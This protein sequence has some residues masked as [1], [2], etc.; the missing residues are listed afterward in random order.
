MRFR[1]I[2]SDVITE[3]KNMEALLFITMVGSFVGLAA[4]RLPISIAL[5][6]S[7]IVGAVI[8]DTF[9]ISRLV[10]GAFG[11][12]DAILIIATAMIFMNSIKESGLLK[13]A[14]DV[15]TFSFRRYP[16]TLLIMMTLFI[17]SAG[18]ITGSSTAAV[19]TTGAIAFPVLTS[20]GLDRKTSGAL[21]AMSSIF[22]M[23]AP[24]VNIPVMI[25]GQGVDMPY[26]GFTYP[27]L[28]LTVPLAL[29]TALLL[30]GRNVK[31]VE[32][33]VRK[34][35][36][37]LI[38]Y[39]PFLLLIVLNI[40]DTLRITSFG[41]SLM[42]I[43][44]AL[45]ANLTAK[46]FNFFKTS[47]KAL[48]EALP[49]LSIL[50]GVGMFIEVMTM[51]GVRGFIVSSLISIPTP[52]LYITIGIGIPAFGAVSSFGAAS[53]LGVPFLLAFLGGNDIIVASALSLVAGLGDMVPPTALAGIFASH[54]V[55]EKNY[56][57]ILK[58]SFAI[59]ALVA[60]FGVTTVAFSRTLSVLFNSAWI[61]CILITALIVGVFL[62]D[63]FA[64]REL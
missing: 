1:T 38:L 7:S 45:S 8:S 63:I 50:A 22:G 5:L 40:L 43:I 29:L 51:S 32:I 64:R 39:I 31:L 61:L 27:L 34:K 16:R 41:L 30:A 57:V 54:V 52:L 33:K 11:Y 55:G 59:L 12:F 14:A 42:F 47:I 36:P 18:M 25:I 4:L 6:F 24:P 15:I 53:V 20:L 56:F 46:K 19:L 60:V 23:I 21:I 3:V 9:S 28:W 58:K 44:C 49:I 62:S 48:S 13:D 17:M 35:K 26:I 2:F 10:E 37:Q